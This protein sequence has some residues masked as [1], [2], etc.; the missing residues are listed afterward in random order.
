MLAAIVFDFDGVI[1]E[2]VD[3]KTRAFQ[4]LF[5]GYPEHQPSIVR[6]HL[7]NAGMSRYEKF[8]RIYAEMLDL[9]LANDEMARLDRDFRVLVASEIERCP[10]VPGAC[11]FL[12]RQAGERPLFVASG[13]PERELRDIVRSRALDRYFAG[14]YGSPPPK[15]VL[16]DRIQ[17]EVRTG[18]SSLL[19]VGDGRQDFEAAA[20]MGIRFVARV[21]PGTPNPFPSGPL[22]TVADLT[23]LQQMWPHVLSYFD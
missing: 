13:T 16:L 18:A 4:R 17:R 1:L 10:F 3:T 9:P 12:E 23:G 5:A 19:F 7:E 15:D 14:V 20:A 11:Q 8:R 22:A 2:S 21:A 6:L